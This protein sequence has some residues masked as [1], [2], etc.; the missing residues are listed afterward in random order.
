MFEIEKY[1]DNEQNMESKRVVDKDRGMFFRCLP[2]WI[3]QTEYEFHITIGD[4]VIPMH[5]EKSIKG[6]PA[7]ID[8]ICYWQITNVG[9]KKVGVTKGPIYS[10]KN[11]EEEEKFT[12]LFI[13]ALLV[14]GFSMNGPSMKKVGQLVIVEHNG[15][16]YPSFKK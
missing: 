13:E 11:R 10:F 15:R 2:G 5:A 7:P 9:G 1:F 14:F 12:Q 6:G 3:E 4:T 16:E 8:Q